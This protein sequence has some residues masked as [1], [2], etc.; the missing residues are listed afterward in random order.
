MIFAGLTSGYLVSQGSYFWVNIKMPSGFQ[1]STTLIIVSSIFLFIGVFALKKGKN[2]LLKPALGI[3]FFCALLFGYYQF[4]GFKQLFNNGSALSGKIMTIEGRYGE[5]FSLSYKS[6]AISFKDGYYYW[7]GDVITDEM[8]DEIR[9]LGEE[10]M[11]G[12]KKS[13]HKYVLSN[14][15]EKYILHYKGEAISYSNNMLYLGEPISGEHHRLLWYFAENLANDRG[16]FIMKGTYGEDFWVYYDG[17]MLDYENRTFYMDGHELSP[18]QKSDLFN[19]DNLASSYIYAL[20]GVH[21]LHWVGGVI[22]LLVV[23][24]RGLGNKYSKE[25]YLGITLASIYWHFLGIL[26][27][28]LYAFLIF[29]H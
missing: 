17:K 11:I 16:D 28:Y 6:K 7:K 9:Q 5:Y 2:V 3:A 1:I 21:L 20:T 15:G 24:I 10:L 4:V 29:I 12:S 18:K 27:L 13:E 22:A 19:Q 8:H 14:Y 25:N 23:F 26:W